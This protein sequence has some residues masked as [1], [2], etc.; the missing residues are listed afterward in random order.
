[1]Q[2][3]LSVCSEVWGCTLCS[4]VWGFSGGVCVC[5]WIV[6]S[7]VSVCCEI[8]AY[9]ASPERMQRDLSSA[10]KLH[11]SAAYRLSRYNSML[12]IVF[13][14]WAKVS[15]FF[16][17]GKVCGHSLTRFQE[18][19]H[20]FIPKTRE[21]EYKCIFFFLEKVYMP[22][23]QLFWR[24]FNK[25]YGNSNFNPIL[26]CIFFPEVCIFFLVFFFLKKV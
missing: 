23:T 20:F 10:G 18:S 16:F 22:L 14:L 4:K 6:C 1:M 9:A 25:K 3:G 2:R 21:K 8:L 17:L 26:R 5:V 13:N 11:K 24:S 15:Y 7:E 19:L 12:G